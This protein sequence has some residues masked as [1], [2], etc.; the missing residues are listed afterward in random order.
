M[1]AGRYLLP[2]TGKYRLLL[3]AVLSACWAGGLWMYTRWVVGDAIS[4]MD[5]YLL[6]LALNLLVFAVTS[7][8]TAGRVFC[9]RGVLQ[10][11][12]WALV[13]TALAIVV[14]LVVISWIAGELVVE[15]GGPWWP[16]ITNLAHVT[17]PFLPAIAFGLADFLL[18]SGA[19]QYLGRLAVEE[20]NERQL[21]V[22]EQ[23]RL[24][25]QL[26]PHLLFNLLPVLRLVI[27]KRTDYMNHGF[28]QVGEI[29]RYYAALDSQ[30]MVPLKDEIAMARRLFELRRLA[31]DAQWLMKWDV[32]AE[33]EETMVLPMLLLLVMEN[34]L[35]YALL[36]RPETPAVI[37]IRTRRGYLSV[38]AQNHVRPGVGGHGLG[39]G[40]SNL[41]SRLSLL[42]GTDYR[43]RYRLHNGVFRLLLIV[44]ARHQTYGCSVV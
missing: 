3:Y 42:F 13:L 35:K 33:T 22:Y 9:G 31:A 16:E 21:T 14:S 19:K 23:D 30:S 26:M 43:L 38:D 8:W 11:L 40:L 18:R 15:P 36:D 24:R 28:E 2:W 29:L 27:R 41:N 4:G 1:E 32:A 20:F 34:K 5:E 25:A 7:Y 39:T 17:A 37:R 44:P 10:K 12:I 6:T